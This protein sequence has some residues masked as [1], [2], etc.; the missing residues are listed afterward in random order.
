M[1]IVTVALGIIVGIGVAGDCAAQASDPLS[2][3][4]L[5]EVHTEPAEPPFGEVF[6]VHLTL[7]FRPDRVAFLP[8]TLL[9]AEAVQSVRPGSWREVPAPG[10]SVDIRA[11]YPVIGLRE[12]RV[13]LPWIELWIGSA[14]AEP[15][16]SDV[17]R[18]MTAV[19]VA[20]SGVTRRM[21]RLGATDIGS[22]TPMRDEMAEIVPRPP[23][24]VLGS[25]WSLWLLLALGVTIVTIGAAGALVLPRWWAG[26]GAAWW[27][28]L[29]GRSPRQVALRELVSIRSA[30]WHRSGRV[31][32]FYAS[33][34]STL[35]H[36]VHRME[37]AWGPALTSNEIL[38][39]MKRRWEAGGL[40]PLATAVTVA[41]RV[42]FGGH[43]PEPEAAEEDWAKVHDW[44]SGAPEA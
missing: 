2:E 38:A 6:D 28:R 30:R 26:R 3:V 23:A 18:R 43:R 20:A 32:D 36:F 15:E 9:P 4:R 27:A 21:I 13:G 10:D 37:P 33:L 29:H 35:R 14:T 34:T 12:G 17:V 39:K 7:R 24:D 5:V 44:I 16:G 41:E 11:T 31:E 19:A 1:R 25:T 42:K 8:D 22:F 40:E